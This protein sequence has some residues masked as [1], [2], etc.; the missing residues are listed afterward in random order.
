MRRLRRSALVLAI[1]SAVLAAGFFSLSRAVTRGRTAE[2]DRRILL[3]MRTAD[4]PSDPVGPRW[5][6]ELCRD[7]TALGGVGVMVLLIGSVTA[8]FWLSDMEHA[9]VYVGVTCLSAV[10]LNVGLK[11]AFDRP[12]PD[13]VPQR[14]HT[15]TSSFPSGH[16]AGA[17]A[18][19]LTL[20][21]VASQFVARRRLKAL[22]LGVAVLVTGAVGASRVY[23]GVHWPTDV[24]GGWCVGAAW[25]LVCWCVASWLQD[26]GVIEREV[27]V[28]A[29]AQRSST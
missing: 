16:S 13:L 23:L 6:E 21:L 10:L 14:M 18:V 24:L 8:F 3:A 26:K 27:K 20:G 7:A 22:F 15:Y 4:D 28:T 19:Y 12:R 5:F 17:A 11:R 2:I 29:V 25:A 1:V 9:A